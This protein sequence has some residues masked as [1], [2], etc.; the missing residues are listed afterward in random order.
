M[1]F[2][3]APR[4]S[5]SPPQKNNLQDQEAIDGDERSSSLRLVHLTDLRIIFIFFQK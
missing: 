5:E 1:T 4:V 2:F 3:L